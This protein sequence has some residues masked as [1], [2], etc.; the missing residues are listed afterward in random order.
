MVEYLPSDRMSFASLG[1]DEQFFS[2]Y[3]SQPASRLMSV[4]APHEQGQL[5]ETVNSAVRPSEP[6]A[7][8][9]LPTAEAAPQSSHEKEPA[10]MSPT[11]SHQQSPDIHHFCPA[12]IHRRTDQTSSQDPIQPETALSDEAASTGGSNPVVAKLA[13]SP[14][15]AI[16]TRYYSS[17]ADTEQ[18]P[19]AYHYRDRSPTITQAQ[20]DDY[21]SKQ[22][23]DGIVCNV[24]AFLSAR[25]R[26]GSSGKPGVAVIDETDAPPSSI[27]P[28]PDDPHLKTSV[29]PED[30][31]LITADNIA[32][33]LDIAIAGIRS[34]QDDRA[35]SDC[36]S[37]LFSSSAYVKPTLHTQ[38]IIPGVSAVA[39]PATTIC[40]P[41]PCFSFSDDLEEFERPRSAPKTTYK[42]LLQNNTHE[43]DAGAEDSG[44]ESPAPSRCLSLRNPQDR[45]ASWPL[46]RRVVQRA[47][48][49]VSPPPSISSPFEK[50]FRQSGQRS[51][52]EPIPQRPSKDEFNR[53]TPPT[54]ITSFPRLISRSCTNDWLTP[55]GLIDAM[56]NEASAKRRA[57]VAD[58][59]HHGVDAHSGVC[60]YDALPILE[61]DPQSAPAPS[62][63]AP[64][65]DCYAHIQDNENHWQSRDDEG[66]ADCGK[67]LG[68]S[69]G[70]ASHRR[71]RARNAHDQ[72][73]DTNENL[74][75]GLRRYSF[76]P[77]SDQ[78]PE[79]IRTDW[80][81]QAS[82]TETPL[83][84]DKQTKRSSRDFLQQ[85]LH[86]SNQ[87][88]ITRLGSKPGSKAPNI[89]RS[90][91]SS[92]RQGEAEGMCCSENNTPRIRINERQTEQSFT[93]NE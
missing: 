43:N 86:R 57:M 59:Y 16:M 33:I 93:Q 56:E 52:S 73:Q 60:I 30:Q 37:L 76:V 32:G 55:L 23:V 72:R 7:S 8:V 80:P 74:V 61:E 40:S 77:L 19:A 75:D 67:K 27:Q 9:C 58:L 1:D 88:S 47:N 54:P 42:N 36:R 26:G 48:I 65:H 29:L 35:Q 85:I 10:P 69:L 5:P 11:D 79:P 44:V 13:S 53:V 89:A 22:G 12:S 83:E 2:A 46:S 24:R 68:S 50:P 14:A 66:Y 45:H 4:F 20:L 39:D 91:E 62:Q 82:L 31:Y 90:Q 21:V 84:G 25:R 87:S 49:G 38:N 34:I 51:T 71:I 28:S 63:Q 78:I 92:K 15:P 17:V 81:A 41:Q 70:A 6:L 64:P 3:S 18:N